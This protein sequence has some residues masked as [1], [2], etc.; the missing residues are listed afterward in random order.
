[1]GLHISTSGPGGRVVIDG[2][3]TI[4]NVS[5][6]RDEIGLRC[7]EGLVL[8]VDLA[9]VTE[10]DPAGLQWLAS[11]MRTTGLRFVNHSAAVRRML[12]DGHAPATAPGAIA[13]R[14]ASDRIAEHAHMPAGE[15][16]S[17]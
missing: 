7:C 12:A 10:I 13:R 15:G 9:G 17:R 16:C 11:G 4:R 8:E 1:M 2:T 14:S 5:A 6:V 3:L